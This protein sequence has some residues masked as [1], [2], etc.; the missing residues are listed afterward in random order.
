[1][2]LAQGTPSRWLVD[3]L[4]VLP[5]GRRVLDVASGRGRH[6]LPLVAAGWTVHAIDRDADALAALRDAARGLPGVLTTEVVDL[7]AGPV[8][9]GAGTY[10]GV[11]VFN[12]LYRP[13]L[14]ALIDALEPGG[15]L[16]YETFT[17]GQAARGHP[18]NPAFL[19]DEGE[20]LRLVAPL[21]V[22]QSFEG[23]RDGHLIASI[24]ARRG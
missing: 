17:R 18:T 10:G 22:L 11:V 19:L 14:P 3:H 7:E 5:K 8:T 2:P 24:V 12:Y 4:D 20:L 1:M 16:L 6:A 15:V 21:Q 9:L 23:E 13:L